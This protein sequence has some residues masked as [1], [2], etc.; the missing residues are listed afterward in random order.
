MTDSP[1]HTVVDRERYA[2]MGLAP[3]MVAP[4]VHRVPLQL[5]LDGLRAVNV[6]VIEDGDGLAL[7]DGGWAIDVSRELLERSLGEIG[8]A[9]G[10]VRRVLVTDVHRNHYSQ[11]IAIRRAVRAEVSLGAGE[12]PSMRHLL[13]R[14]VTTVWTGG[15][16]CVSPT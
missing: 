6:Y 7:I 10:D 1:G 11:A 13:D 4:G 15:A 9:L 8:Y 16:S 3:E 5:P 2:R 14:R 12:Q